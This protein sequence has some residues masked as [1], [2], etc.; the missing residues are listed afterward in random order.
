[1][2]DSLEV[3]LV[4]LIL[5][6]SG[7]TY[8]DF[9]PCHAIVLSIL[10]S[11]VKYCLIALRAEDLIDLAPHLVSAISRHHL[12]QLVIHLYVQQLFPF[13]VL[14]GVLKACIKAITSAHHSDIV[15]RSPCKEVGILR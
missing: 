4:R 15:Y 11:L 7:I 10:Y 14:D 12:Q 9:E 8:A 3:R 2:P 1:M 5:L 6:Q 13:F